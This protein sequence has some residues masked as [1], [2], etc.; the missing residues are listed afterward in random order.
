MISLPFLYLACIPAAHQAQPY[1]RK[2]RHCMFP[3]Q[4]AFILTL[5]IASGSTAT[6]YLDGLVEVP[7]LHGRFNSGSPDRPTGPVTL[8]K[9]P[10]M[11]AEVAV[12]VR[13][14][15][16]LESRNHSYEGVSAVVY[17]RKQDSDGRWWYK[18]KYSDGK[19]HMFAWLSQ[20]DAGRFR[21][22]GDLA[23]KNGMPFFTEGW[24]K[25]LYSRPET[26]ASFTPFEKH[27]DSTLVVAGVRY[28]KDN[29]VHWF[30]VMIVEGN[31]CRGLGNE[32]GSVIA[33]GWVPA[34]AENGTETIW[35]GIC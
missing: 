16:Q 14:R 29:K 9:E 15:S 21:L 3:F 32:G 26:S 7:A 18:L 35:W 17:D 24:G 28:G 2:M 19:N 22:Y 10:S 23:S 5:V 27:D 4:L 34:Y 33:T 31:V 8:F 13:D 12:V 20:A 1:L 30:L 25:R 6:E 11:N